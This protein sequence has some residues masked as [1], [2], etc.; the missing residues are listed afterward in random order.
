L[1]TS[2]TRRGRGIKETK[3]DFPS[4]LLAWRLLIQFFNSGGGSVFYG[5]NFQR[6]TGSIIACRPD[7]LFQAPRRAAI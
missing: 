7:F 3:G 4:L 6:P 1:L 5:I 2:V